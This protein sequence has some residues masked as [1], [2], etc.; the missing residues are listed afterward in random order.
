MNLK[1]LSILI[2]LCLPLIACEG[3]KKT[4]N[5]KTPPEI[6]NGITDE[7]TAPPEDE[8]DVVEEDP[9]PV[10]EGYEKL[11]EATGDL[12]NDGVDEKVVVYN[13]P[14]ETDMGTEREIH[15]YKKRIRLGPYGTRQLVPYY[16]QSMAG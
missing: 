6:T 4:D 12:D 2:I 5:D 1:T 10:L 3:L 14:R 7:E 11:G 8:V 15:I 16:P 13:T 9:L